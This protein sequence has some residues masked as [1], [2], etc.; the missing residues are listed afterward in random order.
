[1]ADKTISILRNIWKRLRDMGDGTHAEIV[2]AAQ[3]QVITKQITIPSGGSLSEAIDLSVGKLALILIP[4]QWTAA[5]LTFQASP[6]GNTFGDLYDS[7]GTEYKV[8]VGAAGRS[9]LVPI[10][11]FMSIR[12]LKI[13][14]GTAGVPVNQGGDRVL[15]LVLL[16]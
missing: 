3:P 14:S 1:M 12:F 15:T 10:G 5:E 16:P 7:I 8:L 6:D 9:I 11:D 2:V 4:A 13:R